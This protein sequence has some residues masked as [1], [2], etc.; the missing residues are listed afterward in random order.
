MKIRSQPKAGGNWSNHNETLG[1][2]PSISMRRQVPTT[3]QKG[4]RLELLVIR[5]G[6]RGGVV[7]R[8]RIGG[9]RK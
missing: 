1:R 4:D 7:R 6:L 8:L 9:I 3:V 2:E 5:T